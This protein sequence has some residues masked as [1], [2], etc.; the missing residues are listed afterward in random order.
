MKNYAKTFALISS[1]PEELEPSL[2]RNLL[3]IF[4]AAPDQVYWIC[5]ALVG[6][7][8]G[9][10]LPFDFEGAGFALTALFIVLMVEQIRR[11]KKPA[12]L[13]SPPWFRYWRS[14]SCPPVS[15]CPARS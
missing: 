10:L 11:V 13:S 9:A 2:D 4:I 6:V 12:P 8:A 14:S 7:A 3:M 1:L 15:P 5:G